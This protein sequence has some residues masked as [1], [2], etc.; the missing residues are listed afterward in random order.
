M[1]D[2]KIQ[3]IVG[4]SMDRSLEQTFA[5]I[6]K[7][8]QKAGVN[9]AKAMGV[10]LSG[11]S[12]VGGNSNPF[13]KMAKDAGKAAK[14]AINSVDRQ[15][16]ETAKALK[17][18]QGDWE[19]AEKDKKKILD[20]SEKDFQRSERQKTKDAAQ[21]ID[22]RLAHEEKA[23]K[24]ASASQDRFAHR[25]SRY[26]LRSGREMFSAAGRF[27]RDIASGAGVDMS[28]GSLVQRSVGIENAAVD[29][30]NR[31]HIEGEKGA[32]GGVVSSRILEGE[33]R[34]TGLATAVNPEEI[35]AAGRTFVGLTG[36]LDT[37][38][39]IMPQVTKQTMAMGGS[40]EDA[41]KMA[42]EFA[43]HIGDIPNKAEHVM[44]MMMVAA[45]Q[46]KIGGIDAT[47][48]AKYASRVAA[49]AGQ[50]AGDKSENV[51][52]LTAIAEIAKM[53]GGAANPA[54]AMGSI[55]QFSN[56]LKK[57]ART[58][59][60]AAL[61]GNKNGQFT[62]DQHSNMRGINEIMKDLIW[63]A[64]KDVHN[65]NGPRVKANL[66]S[67][68]TATGDVRGAK[69][70]YGLV[71]TF[72]T[73]GGGTKG[74]D[75]VNAELKRFDSAIMTTTE[76]ERAAAEKMETTK[77]QTEV[78]NQQLEAVSH[79]VMAELGPAI[80]DLAPDAIKAAQGLG[81]LASWAAGHPWE[82]AGAAVGG[83]AAKGVGEALAR[84][85]LEAAITSAAG[86][87]IA[88]GAVGLAAA[89]AWAWIEHD[90]SDKEE[91]QR[92]E[93]ASDAALGVA[94]EGGLGANQPEFLKAKEEE[95]KKRLAE[96]DRV[97]KYD[98]GSSK[99][100]SASLRAS[101]ETMDSIPLL[102]N[103]DNVKA[104]QDEQHESGLRDD[105]QKIHMMLAN[106]SRGI[107]VTN[108]DQI[109]ID[110]GPK[111]FKPGM[112]HDPGTLPAYLRR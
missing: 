48:F 16:K 25:A 8:A 11:G 45:G 105:L 27:G 91:K 86:G 76:L 35:L 14:A 110:N 98:T 34:K 1:S 47:E 51:G 79:G 9:I 49:P 57:T 18:M 31:G 40:Q 59:S 39:K 43:A 13:D 87:M 82:A 26:A 85:G 3:I 2:G 94:E 100:D 88:L 52:K 60:I 89:A 84:A 12:G 28:V 6:E 71:D 24:A 102:G 108:L 109:K 99:E 80:K 63:G 112:E 93:A 78:F 5:S 37:W 20:K 44:N 53:H 97:K 50:F 33:A 111:V 41:A 73:A 30:S 46:G 38:R 61:I 95:I 74:M 69:A 68:A 32:N 4:A 54:E 75:A 22:A 70:L 107:P 23:A 104:R 36:D 92:K 72:N 15:R 58:K 103:I 64:A 55:T 90:I 77:S 19:K 67:I 29:L 21:E 101:H 65:P 42:G 83:A 7:R 56:T 106:I 62:D 66:N 17:E 96:V 10:G 81:S